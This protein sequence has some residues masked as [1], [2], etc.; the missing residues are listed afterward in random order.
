MIDDYFEFLKKV[1]SSDPSVKKFRLIKECIGVK[2]G[3]IRFVIELR[4][5]I[6]S[7]GAGF[8]GRNLVRV[9]KSE[10]YDMEEVTVLDKDEEN[11]EY[12]KRYGVKALYVD[13]A[14]KGD[15]YA[16]FNG[17]EMVI[18]L[19]AQISSP[20]PELFYRNNVLVTRNVLEAARI[21]GVKRIVHFSSA[22]VLSVRKDC[23]AETKVEAEEL[24][25][26]VG[27]STVYYSPPLCMDQRMTK[28]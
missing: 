18:N 22:A 2:R 15:W 7:G 13:L 27:L 28:I 23:Y 5:I 9:L 16:E 11:L 19:A 20:D 6:I 4:D 24:V 10:N 21:A 17:K 26:K 1:A 12:V 8:V 14:E 25:K 3:Y